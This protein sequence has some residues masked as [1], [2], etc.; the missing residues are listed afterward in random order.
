MRGRNRYKRFAGIGVAILLLAALG[1][2]VAILLLADRSPFPSSP[3]VALPSGRG[4]ITQ[5]SVL[6]ALMS[7][8]YDGVMPIPELLRGGDFGLGTLDHLDGELI[9]LDGRA[10]QVR[11][12]GVVVAVGPDRS[13]PF[14]LVT[15]FA[16]D[17]EFACP[18]VG[19]IA[20]L[21]ARL[22]DA[23]GRKNHF[24]AVRVD[25]RF[26]A[27]TLRSVHRQEPPYRP[28]GEVVKGQSVWT[29]GEVSG[30]LVGIR[31]PAWIGGL[32]VPGYHW[33]F[34]S[35]D[36]T[37]GGHVLDCR[38]REVRVR[39][40]VCHDWRIKLDRSAG[41]KGVDLGA[42]L[43]HDLRRVERSR[44]EGAQGGGPGR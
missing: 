16:P 21:D 32:N 14:A 25:G 17:G 15:P 33:H 28:L 20:D 9:V 4:R 6:N 41:C 37:V 13:T 7:G 8:R 2:G 40:Q 12:D 19:N 42:D 30:T 35:D 3:P 29:H 10:Y 23:L 5:V 36:H 39:F 27:I 1:T 18:R 31:C 22:D 24:L 11:G 38:A 26:A 34:L 44:G 43:S